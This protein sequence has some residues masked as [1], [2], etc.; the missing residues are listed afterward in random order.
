MTTEL[1]Y[2]QTTLWWFSGRILAW[3]AGRPGSIPG[4][5]KQKNFVQTPV[6]CF[7][8]K[9]LVKIGWTVNTMWFYVIYFS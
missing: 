2:H 9:Q 8:R 5:W 1:V 6:F 7:A 4:Q 3:H